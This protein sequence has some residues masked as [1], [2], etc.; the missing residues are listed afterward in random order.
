MA[1]LERGIGSIGDALLYPNLAVKAVWQNKMESR[2]LI[3][4]V[5]ASQKKRC[6][7]S[8]RR[9]L[10]RLTRLKISDRWRER[11]VAASKVWKPSKT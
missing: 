6:K 4:Q 7:Q 9:A 11:A 8:E 5:T 10:H 1:S 2:A 3:K